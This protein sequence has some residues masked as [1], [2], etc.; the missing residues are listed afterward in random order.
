MPPFVVYRVFHLYEFLLLSMYSASH[1]RECDLKQQVQLV[2]NLQRSVAITSKDHPDRSKGR[3]HVESPAVVVVEMTASMVAVVMTTSI[4]S[5]VT[6][7]S[8]VV[9][10]RLPLRR[11]WR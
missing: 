2:D 3:Q 11:C 10:G 4:A 7:P 9:L 6:T 8:L 1:I 5:K